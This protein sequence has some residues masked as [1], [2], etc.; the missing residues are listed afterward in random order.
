MQMSRGVTLTKPLKKLFKYGV[1]NDKTRKFIIYERII[2]DNPFKN[3]F[4]R[5]MLILFIFS[6]VYTVSFGTRWFQ[7]NMIMSSREF[8]KSTTPEIN[9][10]SFNTV[11]TI[12]VIRAYQTPNS[13]NSKNWRTARKSN[14]LNRSRAG[15]PPKTYSI[16]PVCDPCLKYREDKIVNWVV[17]PSHEGWSS[18]FSD[19]Y[20]GSVLGYDSYLF[21]NLGLRNHFSLGRNINWIC[22]EH[23]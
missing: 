2:H 1:R 17:I 8:I 14:S 13:K 3:I 20:V 9:Q 12:F 16:N 18:E 7:F 22:N 4:R 23:P 6:K 15:H 19:A 11:E 21:T 10:S 5:I